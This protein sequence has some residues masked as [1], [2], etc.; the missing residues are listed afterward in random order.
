M[1]RQIY[2]FATKRSSFF[3]PGV[4]N[5]VLSQETFQSLI[6]HDQSERYFILKLVSLQTYFFLVPSVLDSPGNPV[7]Y[8]SSSK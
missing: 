4:T 5:S 7:V 1:C 6:L 2:F 3:L 8:Q